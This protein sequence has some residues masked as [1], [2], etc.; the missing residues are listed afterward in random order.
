MSTRTPASRPAPTA[1]DGRPSGRRRAIATAVTVVV[2]LAMAGQARING[3]LATDIGDGVLAAVLSFGGGLLILLV[4]ALA[5]PGMRRGLRRVA[6]AV[7]EQR[8]SPWHLLGGVCGA[9][10]V[11]S[12]GLAVG[13]LGVAV[14]TV[15]VVAGQTTSGLL[16]DRAGIGPGGARPVTPLRVLGA[17]LALGAVL[18]SVAERLGAP[19]A[20]ALAVL[21]ALA[22]V[23]MAWQQAVNGRV[24]VAAGGPLPAALV[25]F[26]VGTTV[27]VLVLVVDV[28]VRG[29]PGPLP[30][31]PVLYLGGPLGVLF[32][33]A[34]A[35]VVPITGVLLLGL[36][37]VAGQVVGALLLDLLVPAGGN[38]H[39]TAVTVVGTVLTL[40]A[41]SV[42]AL[43]AR[44]RVA[45]SG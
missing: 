45:G 29:L 30:G 16:V 33:G 21:P 13:V 32:I 11:V 40:L 9:F 34:A 3:Q 43:P 10:L 31:D 37:T 18:L 42:A 26:V 2:G 15:A 8:L 1:E 35:A 27:L 24:G 36:G 23:G 39:L 41:V 14:F 7:R 28:L 22:G 19:A 20:L 25:N 6:G 17:A 38:D 44:R 5:L 4:L 12:Q